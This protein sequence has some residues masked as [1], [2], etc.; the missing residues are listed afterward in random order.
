MNRC[1][2]AALIC[3]LSFAA[4]AEAW[5]AQ[6]VLL[7]K[8]ANSCS[9]YTGIQYTFELKGDTLTVIN[10]AG[11]MGSTQIGHDGAASFTFK[12]PTGALL[13]LTGNAKARDLLITNARSG[14]YWRY[15]ESN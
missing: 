3:M 14:C 1:A 12:S 6:G 11:K 5:K 13:T 8:S 4:N 15:K 2:C 7:E 9:G 10:A